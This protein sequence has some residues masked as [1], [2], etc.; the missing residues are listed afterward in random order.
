MSTDF[1][2]STLQGISWLIWS[3]TPNTQKAQANNV[4]SAS[5]K[6]FC[7]GVESLAQVRSAPEAD[8]VPSCERAWK[9]WDWLAFLRTKLPSLSYLELRKKEYRMQSKGEVPVQMVG[10]WTLK[11]PL[12]GR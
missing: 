4:G 10:S 6:T 3:R 11:E 12:A 5:L 2:F 8:L 7:S 9:G 1:K